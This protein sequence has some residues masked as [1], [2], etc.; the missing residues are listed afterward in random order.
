MDT[1]LTNKHIEVLNWIEDFKE[2]DQEVFSDY[3]IN[4]RTQI[5]IYKMGNCSFFAFE[6]QN[7]FPEGEIWVDDGLGHAAVSIDGVLFDI[8]GIIASPDPD[9][10]NGIF[11]DPMDDS[12]H[13]ATDLEIELI[14][15]WSHKNGWPE[16]DL[17]AEAGINLIKQKAKNFYDSINELFDMM[18]EWY[19]EDIIGNIKWT[20]Q[21]TYAET[22]EDLF[23]QL[24]EENGWNDF[25]E[26]FC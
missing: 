18:G 4:E 6:L 8:T 24:T 16:S 9:S 15:A 22:N 5:E 3:I 14:K 19:V 7:A 12:F 21:R 1:K 11:F 26:E 25:I 17:Y 10:Y 13:K 23:N 20:F 2:Q